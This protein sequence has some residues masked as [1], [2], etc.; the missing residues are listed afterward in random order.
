MKSLVK[1][2]LVLSLVSCAGIR[3]MALRQTA[4][5]MGD[6]A[7]EAETEPSW[8]W[9]ASSLPG[10]IK[11]IEALWYLDQ[12]NTDL[13]NALVKGYGGYAFAVGETLF[14]D[15]T[16]KD[17]EDSKAKEMAIYHYSKAT[18][19]GWKYLEVEG[20]SKQDLN[21][22]IREPK[23]FQEKLDKHLGKSD[24]EAVFFLG[25]S[26]GGLL[27]LQKD[28]IALLGQLPMVKGLMDWACGKEPSLQYGSCDIF[29]GVYEAGRPQM[30]GGDPKKGEDILLSAVEKQPHN[31]LNKVLYLQFI[32]IPQANEDKFEKLSAQLEEDFEEFSK[33]LNWGKTLGEK[34]KFEAFSHLNLFN[35]TAKK[36]FEI[37]I[38]NKKELF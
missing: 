1:L 32:A 7:K 31:L 22:L 6:A 24:V 35:A 14:L 16:Y 10:A 38:A 2:L 9:F 33:Q 13:L 8:E 21:S 34:S 3:K 17:I 25:Q 18:Q 28:N 23:Q 29:Y 12:K 4:K 11:N 19:Y 30:L 26:L 36:R 37:M 27:N 5:M 20:I 15:D